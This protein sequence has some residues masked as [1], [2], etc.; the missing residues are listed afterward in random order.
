MNVIFKSIFEGKK[1]EIKCE[2]WTEY[3][4]TN[5]KGES[6]VLEIRE[7]KKRPTFRDKLLEAYNY[8]MEDGWRVDAYED[9]DTPLPLS[10][11]KSLRVALL[12]YNTPFE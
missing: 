2:K 11:L 4:Y 5:S 12:R 8:Q 3:T 1:I 7:I 6:I 10:N 9:D